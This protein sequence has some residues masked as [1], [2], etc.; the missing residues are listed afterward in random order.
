MT[1]QVPNIPTDNSPATQIEPTKT[2]LTHNRPS[3]QAP[4]IADA[5]YSPVCIE[6]PAI[7]IPKFNGDPLAFHDW[8]NIFKATVHNNHSITQTHRIT[9]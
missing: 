5:N 1:Q 8:I 4:H 7:Q 9:F 2:A 6:V 3:L